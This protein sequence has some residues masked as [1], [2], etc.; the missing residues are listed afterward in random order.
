[1]FAREDGS[2][3]VPSDVTKV[4]NRLLAGAGVRRVRL[5][6][7]RHGAASLMLAGG[8]DIAV[9]SKRMGHSSIRVTADIYS[10]LL[11]GVGRQAADAAEALVPARGA[12]PAPD[13]PT[14]RPHA[15]EDDSTAPPLGGEAAGQNRAAC[16]NRTDDL[17]ITSEMLYRLS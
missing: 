3:L 5:H 7:L 14:L 13:A 1:V 9:V 10:H 8:A 11:Q 4:F 17:L 16:R 6:D 12:H 15:L 2:D